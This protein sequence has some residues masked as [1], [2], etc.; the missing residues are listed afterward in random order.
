LRDALTK[1]HHDN[2]KQGQQFVTESI[3]LADGEPEQVPDIKPEVD[4]AAARGKPEK[5]EPS[6]RVLAVK[7][8]GMDMHG[9]QIVEVLATGNDYAIYEIQHQS[10]GNRLRVLIDGNDDV[11]EQALKEK[12]SLVKQ[13][14]TEAKGLLYR[15]PNFGMMKN[16]IAHTLASCF[17]TDKIDGNAEFDKL[18]KVITSEHEASIFNRVAYLVPSMVFTALFLVVAV[19]SMEFRYE[20][21]SAWQ[22]MT[23]ALASALGGSMS[24]LLHMKNVN[25]EEYGSVKFYTLAGLERIFLAFVAGAI[26]FVLVKAKLLLSVQLASTYWGV[27]AVVAAAGFSEALVPR[28]IGKV[29]KAD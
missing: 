27:M 3:R 5:T 9:N 15:S 17:T 8:G 18:I 20:Y 25:F 21:T 11:S 7:A 29:D 22:V 4:S 28:F 12:F 6:A 19:L 23:A 1:N 2:S 13:K 10:I 16:R 14:Y 26:A 24:I